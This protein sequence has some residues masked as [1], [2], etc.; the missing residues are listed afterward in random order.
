MPHSG[1]KSHFSPKIRVYG[2]QRVKTDPN[3]LEMAKNGHFLPL[4]K[5]PQTQGKIFDSPKLC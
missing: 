3:D 2:V 5:T 4:F 1:Q